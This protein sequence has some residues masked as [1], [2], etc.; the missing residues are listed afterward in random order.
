MVRD[1]RVVP[2]YALSGIADRRVRFSME[3]MSKALVQIQ[4]RE[5]QAQETEPDSLPSNGQKSEALGG[6]FIRI[7]SRGFENLVHK[8]QH[9]LGRVPQG[10]IFIRNRT[11]N[12][13]CVIEGDPVAF[14]GIPAATDKE[15]TFLIGDPPGS[16]VVGILI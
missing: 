12:N 4:R 14:G 16:V 15:V 6:E 8:V 13:E 3:A 7:T 10:C 11:A 1:I 2:G 9:S 5:T